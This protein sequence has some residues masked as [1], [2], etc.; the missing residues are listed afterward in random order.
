MEALNIILTILK[1]A[2]MGIGILA[3][4]LLAIV[5]LVLLVPIRYD[6]VGDLREEKKASIRVH[7]LLHAFSVLLSVQGRAL[8]IRVKILGRT[9]L[10]S[11]EQ[12]GHSREVKEEAPL[13]EGAPPGERALLP[14]TGNDAGEG[15]EPVRETEGAEETGEDGVKENPPS[16]EAPCAEQSEGGAEENPPSE[17]GPRIAIT[18]GEKLEDWINNL[19]DSLAERL[20]H[21]EQ[22]MEETLEKIEGIRAKLS[23]YGTLLSD[24]RTQRLIQ[25]LMKKIWGILRYIAPTKLRANL[26][27]GMESPYQ[28]GQI[29]MAAS[30]LY[31]V[32]RDA[33]QLEP[34][35]EQRVLEGDFFLKGRIRLGHF[36]F[37][38]L[39]VLVNR[40]F[41]FVIFHRKQAKAEKRRPS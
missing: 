10:A 32:Y 5:L 19:S 29:C 28:T 9:L 21:I 15:A 12:G 17:E 16:E 27:F 20:E 31:P 3:G 40:D 2:G 6:A 1:I 35:F 26:H 33:I 14:Q 38:V 39:Q 24:A 34:D 41:W 18:V 7:W 8:Q 13:Q 23:H 25:T 11:G 36:V 30:L 4:L 37:V 22:S